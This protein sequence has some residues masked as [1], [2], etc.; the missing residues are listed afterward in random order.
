MAFAIH[1][2]VMET[3]TTTGTGNVTV[4]GAVAGFQTFGSRYATN[5]TFPYFIE[6]VDAGGAPTGEWETGIGTYNGSNV[7]ARTTVIY[8]SNSDAAVNFSSGTKRVA[9]G[10]IAKMFG[11]QLIETLST[12]SGAS[13]TSAALPTR[14]SDLLVVF[15]GVSHNNGS[16]TIISMSASNNGTNYTGTLNASS[17]VANTVTWY[18]SLQVPGFK[19]DTGSFVGAQAVNITADLTIVNGA[20]LSAQWRVAGGINYLKFAPAAGSFDAGSIKIYGC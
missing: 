1:D 3:S 18:G 14:Y 20:A 4:A 15:D 11:W 6:G 19:L 9:V 10:P 16:A 8:S 12:T 5:D 2:R 13:V 17:T 7:V